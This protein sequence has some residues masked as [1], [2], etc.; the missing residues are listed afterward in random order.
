MSD[1]DALLER[2]LAVLESIGA[3]RTAR[4][5]RALAAEPGVMDEALGLIAQDGAALYPQ[6]AQAFANQQLTAFLQKPARY[7][8]QIAMPPENSPRLAHQAAQEVLTQ[9][10][11]T[12]EAVAEGVGRAPIK[13]AGACVCFGLG[14]GAQIGPLIE[15]LDFRE[16]ILVEPQDSL[17]LA[18]LLYAD[19]AA[20]RDTLAARGG[21][22]SL[23]EGDEPDDL[24]HGI[25]LR[26]RGRYFPMLD[27]LYI[28]RHYATPEIDRCA[29]Q[30]EAL[31]PVVETSDGFFEDELIMLR[32]A[33]DA[34]VNGSYCRL[35]DRADRA[36]KSTPVF[37]AASGPSLD[38]SLETIRK[39]RDQVILISCTTSLRALLAAGLKPD[40]H[41]EVEN[42]ERNREIIETAARDFDISGVVL[43]GA[44]TV[45]VEAI[46][47]FDRAVL[48]W[49]EASVPSRLFGSLDTYLNF[50]GPTAANFALRAGV[51]MG[52]TDFYLFG[53]DLGAVDPDRH[54][55][56]GT[57]YFNNDEPEFWSAGGGAGSDPM[58][59][60]TPGT[61][62]ETVYTN[63][64]FVMA[65]QYVERLIRFFPK[66]R[67]Y[68]CS[69]GA[70][71]AG[72]TPM[73]PGEIP[74]LPVLEGR[75]DL[76]AQC[77]AEIERRPRGADLSLETLREFRDQT[78]AWYAQ[79]L[80]ACE[81]YGSEGIGALIDRLTPLLGPTSETPSY[82]VE[83]AVKAL[84]TGAVT[85]LL[86][87]GWFTVRR[88][89]GAEQDAFLTAFK[90]V[91]SETLT[92]MRR[93][94]MA[95]I[96]A[97]I[98]KTE[99]VNGDG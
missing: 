61:H 12:V 48:Y 54:H 91:L 44:V 82:T 86:Q 2:N 85:T 65:R 33:V 98:A 53:L 18:S 42:T 93:D 96:D 79:A 84:S 59:L 24:A 73:P 6:G 7:W 56:S 75:S 77:L 14:V 21:R 58:T 40:F 66:R 11:V 1:T 60:P 68:N 8:A 35:A 32:Q 28:Y 50:A 36:L 69:D 83:A 26:L 3:V 41:S 72:A 4:R 13:N 55:A 90:T 16:L 17:L 22:L 39:H 70:R 87:F 43:L 10:G 57:I 20:W 47:C 76:I 31:M 19:W 5:L 38:A 88:L 29:A 34:C 30:V 89:D 62:R 27:G 99:A 63:K 25:M 51:S 15:A 97:A 67:Y 9:S 64:N 71:I 81:P 78:D 94:A 23:I 37:I 49:R 52:F 95:E 45:P 74:P 80:A 92:S 46:R